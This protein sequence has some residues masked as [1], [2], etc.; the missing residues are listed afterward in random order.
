[1]FA[2]GKEVLW[3]AQVPALGAQN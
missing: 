2:S 1:L 3:D